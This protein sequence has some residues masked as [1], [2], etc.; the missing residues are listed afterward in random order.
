[1]QN[2]HETDHNS[3]SE[4]GVLLPNWQ[5]AQPPSKQP[6]V[7]RYCEL[8]PL[9][10][11]KHADQ[12]YDAYTGNADASNLYQGWDYLPYGPFSDLDEFRT[13]LQGDCLQDDPMFFVVLCQKSHQALGMASYLNINPKQGSIEVGH[14]HFSPLMQGTTLASEAMYLMMHYV[15]ATLGYRRYEWKCNSLNQASNDSAKRLG[16]VFEGCFR[17]MLVVKGR[18]RDTNWFSIL[19]SEW[20]FLQIA[21][22]NWLAPEN[23]DD[24]GHQK[25]KLE[26]FQKKSSGNS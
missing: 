19:D 11:A 23:F 20:K 3:G 7:G 8:Q 25:Q 5:G 17:Q 13:W 22:E 21:F 1:M 15:F 4:L 6:L 9:D 10:V 18:N 12:L 16:F 14:I 26:Y 2:Q 24:V